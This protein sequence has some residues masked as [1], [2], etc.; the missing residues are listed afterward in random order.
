MFK[1]Y[2]KIGFRNICK[3]KNISIV[4]ILSLTIG[5]AI[6]LLIAAYAH[7]ELS[8]DNFHTKA[9][10]IY[11]VSYG[12]SSFTPGPLSGLLKNEFPEIEQATHIETH[13]LFA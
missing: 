8:V 1:Y 4:N 6:L 7:N 9:S 3:Y 5:I 10:R 12:S 11:K 13:Q 2:I